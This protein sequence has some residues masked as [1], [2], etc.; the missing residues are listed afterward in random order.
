MEGTRRALLRLAAACC[1]LCALPALHNSSAGEGQKTTE[2]AVLSPLLNTVP[3]SH[4]L[5]EASDLSPGTTAV[6]ETSL[7]INVTAA[8]LNATGVHSTEV[9]DAFISATPVVGTKT[10]RLQAS[11]AASTTGITVIQR[12]H[13]NVSLS[14][15]GTEIPSPA[16]TVS[17]LEKNPPVHE[18]TEPF[19]TTKEM[20]D[21]SSATPTPPLNSV[22]GRFCPS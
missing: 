19:S 12:E 5:R 4:Q 8:A 15:N 22:P 6:P 9:E 17:T 2:T 11:T 20:D 7:E 10:E 3:T 21:A 18:A 13:H 1:L 16:S 14:A